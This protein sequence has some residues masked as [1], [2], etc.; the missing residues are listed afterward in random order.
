MEK[1]MDSHLLREI[2]YNLATD[3]R[4]LRTERNLAVDEAAQMSKIHLKQI[5]NMEMGTIKDWNIL[6]RL[7][8]FYGKKV[9]VQFY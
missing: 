6:V 7:A 3:L 9:R 4:R 1:L 8:E 2:R 5:Q